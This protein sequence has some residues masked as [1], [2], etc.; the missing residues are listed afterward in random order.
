MNDDLQKQFENYISECTYSKRLRPET[1]RGYEAVFKNFRSLMPE[2]THASLLTSETT[3]EFF[4]RLETRIRIVGR[5]EE[6]KGV[7]DSTIKTYWSKLHSFFRW[8]VENGSIKVNPITKI[9]PKEPKYTDQRALKA[10]QVHKIVS[11][12][13]FHSQ[14][15]FIL[16]RDMAIV[17]LLLFCGLR[18]GELIAV[19]E[20][21]IDFEKCLLRV[22]GETSKSG[23][24]RFIPMN[25]TL[26]F[27]LKEYLKERA[28]YGYKTE[29][30]LASSNQDRGLSRDG[31][32]H[33]V[34]RLGNQSGVRFH[35][36][37]FRHTFATTLAKQNTHIA[38]I[39]LLL[40]HKS[41][42][43]TV[44]YLRSITV[45]DTRGD[46]DAFNIDI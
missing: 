45:E 31:L 3:N 23:E 39:Q 18:R 2:I 35:L 1:I 6:R 46:I 19:Q 11:T 34:K 14:K 22:R 30:L 37:Q 15:V 12:I 32:K 17:S 20:Q 29:Y 24:D 21:D 4:K 26:V 5:G 9:R 42:K 40:G 10:E 43:M 38:K 33:W 8:L 36:H 25:A 28:N 7:R 13:N 44:R 27:H 16:K 41:W